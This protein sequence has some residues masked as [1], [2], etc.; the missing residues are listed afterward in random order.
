MEAI[1]MVWRSVL[2]LWGKGKPGGGGALPSCYNLSEFD[3]RSLERFK[4]LRDS[5]VELERKRKVYRKK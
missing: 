2:G 5:I 3:A 4:R 1:G